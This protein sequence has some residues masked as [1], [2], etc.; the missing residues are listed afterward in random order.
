MRPSGRTAEPNVGSICTVVQAEIVAKDISP[1]IPLACFGS[2]D[3]HPG[4]A[5]ELLSDTSAD[6][7]GGRVKVQRAGP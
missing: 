3:G 7:M 5:G 6:N 4:V 1:V 2:P